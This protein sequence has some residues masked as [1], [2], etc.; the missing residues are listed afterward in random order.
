MKKIDHISV[1][2]L[3]E[4]ENAVDFFGTQT[5]LAKELGLNRATVTNWM[6]GGLTNIPPLFAYRLCQLYP[7]KFKMPKARAVRYR[8]AERNL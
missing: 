1:D 5:Q 8:K 6:S 3:I 4:I 7:G 2:P